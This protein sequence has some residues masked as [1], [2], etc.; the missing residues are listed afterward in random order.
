MLMQLS[1][2]GQLSLIRSSG[3][4]FSP[5]GRPEIALPNHGTDAALDTFMQGNR[6]MH[7][8]KVTGVRCI[9]GLSWRKFVET[10][11]MFESIGTMRGSQIVYPGGKGIKEIILGRNW[12]T[13]RGHSYGTGRGGH[14]SYGAGTT[15]VSSAATQQGLERESFSSAK[16]SAR[17]CKK[18]RAA[19]FA[20]ENPP[21][22]PS[23][24]AG[25]P[26]FSLPPP[27]RRRSP[28]AL[29]AFSEKRLFARS[30]SSLIMSSMSRLDP[31]V[32]PCSAA[33]TSAAG[34]LFV[35]DLERERENCR[36]PGE[37]LSSCRV[38]WRAS[39]Y[40]WIIL[41]RVVG[42]GS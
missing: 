38:C 22:L 21:H 27:A 37:P 40:S 11:T 30:S 26:P 29:A 34:F 32:C 28:G 25:Q 23:S 10:S 20:D 35:V 17:S 39:P 3:L 2:L 19:D 8:H 4:S 24:G 1:G 9:T 36:R 31:R 33:R 7:S 16:S 42:E 14:I 6:V 12:G 15:H 13:G 41:L 18:C 5:L